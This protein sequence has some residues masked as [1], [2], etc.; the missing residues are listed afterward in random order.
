MTLEVL[1]LV[2]KSHSPL[3]TFF[4]EI[5]LQTLTDLLLLP[6]AIYQSV[7]SIDPGVYEIC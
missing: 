2:Q 7:S 3:C 5:T 1:F 4:T 6:V